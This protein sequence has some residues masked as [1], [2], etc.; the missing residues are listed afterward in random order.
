MGQ[1]GTSLY[2]TIYIHLQKNIATK[3]VHSHVQQNIIHVRFV[4]IPKP[5]Y[6]QAEKNG[7]PFGEGSM[8]FF[9]SSFWSA[10]VHGEDW[11]RLKIHHHPP[12]PKKKKV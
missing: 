4:G 11:L 1:H 6:Q 8:D 5:W 7:K 3:I 12:P 10:Q 9:A 2:F